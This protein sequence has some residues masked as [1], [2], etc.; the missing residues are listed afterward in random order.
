M[1]LLYPLSGDVEV[2]LGCR[3]TTSLDMSRP[4]SADTHEKKPR[5]QPR[6]SALRVSLSM[7]IPNLL[8]KSDEKTQVLAAKGL[9]LVID[10]DGLSPHWSQSMMEKTFKTCVF[11]IENGPDG[12]DGFARKTVAEALTP[13][14]SRSVLGSNRLKRRSCFTWVKR[15]ISR[16]LYLYRSL[17]SS[18]SQV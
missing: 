11:R 9:C 6:K 13:Y 16:H 15:S 4:K 14:G 8:R 18:T 10:F 1:Y 3:L 17:L 7:R 5:S 12:H 2:V